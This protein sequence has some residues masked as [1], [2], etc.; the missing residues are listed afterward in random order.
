MTSIHFV[1]RNNVIDYCEI[2]CDASQVSEI[3]RKYKAVGLSNIETLQ[4]QLNQSDYIPVLTAVWSERDKAKRLVW[5]RSVSDQMHAPLMYEQAISEFTQ[6][7]MV[8]TIIHVTMPLIKAAGIR[9]IQDGS[10]SKDPSVSKG[11]HFT[12][13]EIAYQ[14]RLSVQ[15]KKHLNKEW[16]DLSGSIEEN[17]PVISEKVIEILEKTMTTNLPDP[18]WIRHHGVGAFLGNME[19]LSSS[20]HKSVRDML[21]EEFVSQLKTLTPS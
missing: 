15:V 1:N 9:V 12:R 19:M 5:L 13:M 3:I 8:E 21:A 6:N 4:E 14:H 10:C 7:P 17:Y 20:L 2:A 16:A 18:S 11:D